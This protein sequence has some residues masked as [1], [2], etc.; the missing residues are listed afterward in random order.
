MSRDIQKEKL[1]EHCNTMYEALEAVRDQRP[2]GQAILA[3]TL[4]QE[5][6]ERVIKQIDEDNGVDN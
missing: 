6:A 4:V 2:Q 3:L 5:M 1:I